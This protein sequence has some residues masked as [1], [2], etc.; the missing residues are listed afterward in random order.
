METLELSN[1]PEECVSNG[2]EELKEFL[3]EVDSSLREAMSNEEKC[4]KVLDQ[5][6]QKVEQ[7]PDDIGKSE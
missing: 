2:S 3:E 7:C 5:L 1:S 4:S 6:C